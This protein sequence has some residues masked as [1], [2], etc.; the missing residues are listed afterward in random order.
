MVSGIGTV[1]LK[2]LLTLIN[3]CEKVKIFEI[4]E[5]RK[6]KGNMDALFEIKSVFSFIKISDK[7]W[8]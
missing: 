3:V 8:S 5:P 4:I 2:D 7:V 6:L 1:F